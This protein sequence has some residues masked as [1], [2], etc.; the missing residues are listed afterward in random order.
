MFIKKVGLNTRVQALHFII[1]NFCGKFSSSRGQ[2][3]S[4]K[5]LV[6]RIQG[7]KDIEVP[8]TEEML[9][10]YHTLMGLYHTLISII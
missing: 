1:G 7:H 10:L 3:E 5:E 4:V 6:K 9:G 8:I 2:T